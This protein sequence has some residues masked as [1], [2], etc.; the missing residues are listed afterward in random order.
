MAEHDFE[1]RA[2][3]VAVSSP[4][5]NSFQM[6]L[7]AIRGIEGCVVNE[8]KVA[9]EQR[10]SREFFQSELSATRYPQL[11]PIIGLTQ[12]GIGLLRVFPLCIKSIP[13]QESRALLIKPVE[14]LCQTICAI[15]NLQL[16]TCWSPVPRAPVKKV[17]L[18]IKTASASSGP[19]TGAPLDGSPTTCW[20]TSKSR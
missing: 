9:Q 5:L 17:P 20:S 4:F 13:D 2:R 19:Q 10:K 8:R 1:L 16:F 12:G 18:R 14:D 7:A 15:S 3:A 6:R 11:L